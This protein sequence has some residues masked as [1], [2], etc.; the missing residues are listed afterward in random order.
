MAHRACFTLPLLHLGHAEGCVVVGCLKLLLTLM[1][2]PCYVRSDGHFADP[3]LSAQNEIKMVIEAEHIAEA[4]LN[5]FERYHNRD[6]KC[7]RH[8]C[9]GVGGRCMQR[10]RASTS[11]VAIPSVKVW[12]IPPVW[13]GM[14]RGSSCC[15]H[16]AK[17]AG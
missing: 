2:A 3:R 7:G 15:L 12:G 6:P 4:V 14:S 9:Q 11:A 8:L 1:A 16:L 17:V 13:A 5:S 10:E